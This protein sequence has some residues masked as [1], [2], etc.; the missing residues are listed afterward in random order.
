M[1]A[2]EQYNAWLNAGFITEQLD[3][4]EIVSRFSLP[5]VFGTA[6]LRGR[7]EPGL[8]R[9]NTPVV[10]RTTHGVAKFFQNQGPV[11]IAYDSRNNS[12]EFAREAAAVLA[13]NGISVM[14]FDDI[15]PT[16]VLSFSIK[17]L[18]AAGGINI[19]ASHNPREYNGYKVFGSDGAQISTAQAEQIARYIEECEMFAAPG[20]NPPAKGIQAPP[21]ELEQQYLE[22]M[23]NSIPH[24]GAVARQAD[25]FQVAYTPLHGA[26][27]RLVP[28]ALHE[29]GVRH[30]HTVDAQMITVGDFPTV[31]YPNPEDPVSLAMALELAAE[32]QADLV[33]ATDPDSD[34]I[35]MAARTREGGY[36][37]VNGNQIGILFLDYLIH[38]RRRA[39]EARPMAAVTT[40]VTSRMA[41]AVCAACGVLLHETLTGFKYIGEKAKEIEQNGTAFVLGYEESH[42]YMTATYALDKDGIVACALACEVACYYSEQGMTLDEALDALYAKYGYFAEETKNLHMTGP[43]AQERMADAC[44]KL[45]ANPPKELCG[46]K[47]EYV[48]DFLNN[49]QHCQDMLGFVLQ[50]GSK[51][52]VRPSGTEPKIKIY[53]LVC[54]GSRAEA[55]TLAEQLAEAGAVLMQ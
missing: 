53:A 33:L 54:A 37:V 18:G 12:I 9:M 50:G 44:A 34:R 51:L 30:I 27:R 31:A 29:L 21:N 22:A 14:M 39:G 19:T 20:T 10:R 52:M 24:S 38:A 35:G 15:T 13:G 45:R 11:L 55:E 1:T 2:T 23:L 49:K 42:G 28:M 26:G 43:D 7:M 48:E 8:A 25:H 36:K 17:H 5:L 32:K 40:F 47:I 16:P 3:H 6:G 4:A 41:A 46:L